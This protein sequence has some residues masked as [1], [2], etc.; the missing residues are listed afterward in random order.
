MG[1]S[2]VTIVDNFGEE[3]QAAFRDG[4]TLES[5]LNFLG[6]STD[7]MDVTVNDRTG[8]MSYQLQD[9]DVIAL[10]SKKVKSGGL[11][12]VTIVDNF[13]EETQAAF[14]EGDTLGNLLGFLGMSTDNMDV[15]VDD[16]AQDLDYRLQDDD[17]IA[18]TSRKVKSGGLSTVTIVDNFGEETQAAFR[19]G[20]T[21]GNLLSFLGMSSDNMDI[22]VN[23]V[24]EDMDYVLEDGD[25]ITLTSRKVKSGN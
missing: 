15:T 12:T 10:T 8:S 1:L 7:N 21:L 17:V 5:L 9:G 23:D 11:S 3:T 25:E 18:L 13:G 2:T 24:L 14:R 16:R 20:D 19:N 4:D 22:R 6:M